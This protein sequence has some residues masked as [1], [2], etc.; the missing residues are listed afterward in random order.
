MRQT[1]DKWAVNCSRSCARKAQHERNH[2]SKRETKS[3]LVCNKKFKVT[4]Y[5]KH[6][7]F[8]S[9]A[10]SSKHRFGDLDREKVKDKIESIIKDEKYFKFFKKKAFRL[11]LKYEIDPEDIIQDFFLELCQGRNTM[12]EQSAM[13]TIRKEYN[14]GVTGKTKSKDIIIALENLNNI[15][16]IEYFDSGLK[17]FEYIYDLKRLLS[18]DEFKIAWLKIIGFGYYE[19]YENR[20]KLSKREFLNIW[21]KLKFPQPE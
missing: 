19:S 14:R 3:C 5:N 18:E 20:D 6:Q 2:G 13:S 21:N 8:C 17:F 10:C 4:L 16:S 7:T 9:V 15:K 12:I 11:G 1:K